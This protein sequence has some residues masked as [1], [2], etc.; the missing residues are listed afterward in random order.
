MS[1]YLLVALLIVVGAVLCGVRLDA[2]VCGSSFG[3]HV[4]ADKACPHA[5]HHTTHE[6]HDE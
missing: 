4:C 3:V 2:H 5:I 6:G 1:D